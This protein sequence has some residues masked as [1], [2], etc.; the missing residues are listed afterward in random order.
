MQLIICTKNE[1]NLTYKYWDMVPDGRT[2]AA[3]TISL[4]LRRGI[5]IAQQN[6]NMNFITNTHISSSV[7]HYIGYNNYIIYGKCS[8][9]SNTSCL[10]LTSI[11]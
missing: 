10:T 7:F 6:L 4:R 2:D 8:K 9:I 1:L 11:R 5:I 3:K